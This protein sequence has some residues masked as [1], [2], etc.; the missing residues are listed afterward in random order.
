VSRFAFN[1]L[2]KE[3]LDEAISEAG[4]DEEEASA[5]SE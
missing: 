5:A 4:S 1:S 2:R 3:A